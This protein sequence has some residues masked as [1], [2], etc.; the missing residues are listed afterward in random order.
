M[1]NTKQRHQ[2]R[3]TVPAV[4]GMVTLI[5]LLSAVTNQRALSSDIKAKR[6]YGYLVKVCRIGPRPSGSAG[7]ASQQR[8]IAEHFTKLGG[9]VAYQTFDVPHPQTGRPVRGRVEICR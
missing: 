9:Q 6:A 3:W 2:V 1:Q 8:L 7:I 5:A 4:A